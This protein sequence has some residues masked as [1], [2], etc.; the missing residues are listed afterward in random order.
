ML[1]DATSTFQ[2][3]CDTS[4]MAQV[5]VAGVPRGFRTRKGERMSECCDHE[6]S[7]ARND[8]IGPVT[9]N[10]GR[11]ES[12]RR[13]MSANHRGYVFWLSGCIP[14][15]SLHHF[16]NCP[17]AARSQSIS[18]ATSRVSRAIAREPSSRDWS[19]LPLVHM[20]MMRGRGILVASVQ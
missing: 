12:R 6:E 18:L 13:R 7:R 17:F 2:D 4:C 11:F 8:A 19:N 1:L 5:S 10:A 3:H 14:P 15:S 20:C 16:F 9:H